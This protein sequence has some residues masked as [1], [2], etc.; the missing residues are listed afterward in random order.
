[1]KINE[2][3]IDIMTAFFRQLQYYVKKDRNV[4]FISADHGAW[5]LAD[6][7]KKSKKSVYEYRYF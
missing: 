5:A 6:F 1:M 3:N 7:K 4:Y 2:E